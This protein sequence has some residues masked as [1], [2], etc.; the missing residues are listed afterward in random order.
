MIYW[1]SNDFCLFFWQNWM[2]VMDLLLEN[3]KKLTSLIRVFSVQWSCWLM[4]WTLRQESF[5]KQRMKQLL[6]LEFFPIHWEGQ[7]LAFTLGSIQSVSHFIL[8]TYEFLFKIII[9]FTLKYYETFKRQ[10]KL[11]TLIKKVKFNQN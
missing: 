3:W 1:I 5:W 8:F 2:M 9:Q 11:S 10:R 7:K 4:Q 6:M